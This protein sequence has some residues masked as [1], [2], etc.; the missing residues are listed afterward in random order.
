[1]SEQKRIIN[2]GVIGTGCISQNHLMSIT[3]LAANARTIWNRKVKIVLKALCD[4]DEQKLKMMAGHFPAEKLYTNP[5]DLIN[6]PEIHAIFVLV[7]TC[8]H[9]D[10][11]IAACKAKKHVFVEKPLAFSDDDIL[12]MIKARDENDVVVQPGLVF[13]SAPQIIYMKKFMED[14]AEKFGKLTNII[15]RDSQEKPYTGLDSHGS[16]WRADYKKAHAGILFEH[17]IHDIDGLIYMLGEIDEVYFKVKYYAGKENIE[18]SVA[19]IVNFKNEVSLTV[20]SMWN[21]IK[22]SA[23]RYEIYFEKA[24]IIITVD[25]QAGKAVSIR[26]KYLNEEEKDLED[27]EMVKY[28]LDSIGFPNVKNELTGPYYFEDLR[29]INAIYENKKAYPTLEHGRYVQKIIEIAYESS[30]ENKPKKLTAR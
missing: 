3:L 28:F 6:D 10:L 19:G 30:K 7:P 26:Y 22:F 13:R 12:E 9:K 25:E 15:F 2:I 18:D 27:S 23:R 21:D 24:Y 5:Y 29:F 8:D 4:I 17:T 11:T 1:M 20:N 14:N 16:T